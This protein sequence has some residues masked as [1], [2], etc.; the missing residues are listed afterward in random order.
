MSFQRF[1]ERS[2]DMQDGT[3][4]HVFGEQQYVEGAGSIVKVK[5]TD[6]EDEEATV[7]NI[8]GVSFNLPKDSDTEVMLLSSSSDTTLKMAILTIP[9]DKQRRW[10]EGAGGV[11]HPTDGDFALEFNEKRAHVTQ[12]KFAVGGKGEFELKEENGE[13]VCYVRCKKFIV[14]GEIISNTLIKSPTAVQGME[15]IPDFETTGGQASFSFFADD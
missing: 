15:K 10:G 2:R 3:E 9:R 8:G 1:R 11:Q 7:L 14:E 12:P 5:G 6:T 4:R 13:A